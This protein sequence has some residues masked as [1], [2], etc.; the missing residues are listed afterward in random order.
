MMPINL[1]L[2]ENT[3]L[4][5]FEFLKINIDSNN[6]TDFEIIAKQE[7]EHI[8][9]N[10]SRSKSRILSYSKENERVVFESLDNS[11]TFINESTS[12]G[13]ANLHERVSEFKIMYSVINDLVFKVSYSPKKSNEF[14]S[15]ISA[16]TALN[17]TDFEINLKSFKTDLKAISLET[18]LNNIINYWKDDVMKNQIIKAIFSSISIARPI[19]SIFGRLIQCMFFFVYRFGNNNE[20]VE[21]I[22]EKIK[23]VMN[24]VLNKIV[25]ESDNV[26]NDNIVYI[27]IN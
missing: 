5:I 19:M 15:C 21:S 16:L 3:L 10:D 17:V 9:R 12:L 2:D 22:C 14:C 1:L 24:S 4:F 7:S 6:Q 25:I 8:D 13:S 18:Y 26:S 23:T 11:L 20:Y 27:N